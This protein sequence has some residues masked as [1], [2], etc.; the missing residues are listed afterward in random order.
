MPLNKET[1]SVILHRPFELTC[2]KRI[3]DS[4]KAI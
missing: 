2:K 1:K 4:E 3:D